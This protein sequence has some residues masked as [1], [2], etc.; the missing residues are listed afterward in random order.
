[1]RKTKRVLLAL[2]GCL[3]VTIASAQTMSLGE[4]IRIGIERNLQLAEKR[5]DIQKGETQIRQSRAMLLPQ[6]NGSLQVIDYL[7]H[8]VQ[9]S[10]SVYLNMDFPDEPQWLRVRTMQY[11]SQ[12]MLQAQMPLYNQSILAAIDAAKVVKELYTLSYEKAVETLTVQ[13]AKTYY[14]AQSCKEHRL[15]LDEDVNRMTELANIAKALLT[16]GV[17][18]ETDYT[19]I[20]INITNLETQRAQYQMVLDQQLNTLRF[21]LDM[22]ATDAI[23]VERMESAL[24]IVPRQG[25]SSLMPDQKLLDAQHQLT[26]KQIK[27]TRAGYLPSIGL[28]GQ[29]GYMG[30]Q[31][32]FGDFFKKFNNHQFGMAAVGLQI[33]IPIFDA[34][35]KRLKVR[36]YKYDAEK[37]RTNRQLLDASLQKDYA[38]ATLQLTQNEQIFMTQS[39]NHQQAQKVYELTAHRYK[40]G[41][42]S[43]TE[44]LQDDMRLIGSEQDMV[45]AHL[46]YNL[47]MIDYL[48]LENNLEALK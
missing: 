31:E 38:N 9:V 15:L 47:A 11:T 36:Q 18:L 12:A 7:K 26:E 14:A 1:M 29:T 37:N 6:V 13:I 17:I 10:N 28:F 42:A 34:N 32:K 5:I 4:C 44:L 22:E 46:Q 21:L 25:M 19:R 2:C 27:L 16:Q 20:S 30:Y 23:D 39:K 3:T 43:M 40:E 8:P 45:N 41:V 48:R 24:S 33:N 35:E